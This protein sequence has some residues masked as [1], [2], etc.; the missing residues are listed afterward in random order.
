MINLLFLK[1]IPSDHE[2]GQSEC[3]SAEDDT[4]V[5]QD[6]GHEQLALRSYQMELADPALKG[7]NVIIVAPTGSGKT[8][9]ALYITKV[10]VVLRISIS[11]HNMSCIDYC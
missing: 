3:V 9:V 2:D 1:G 5:P 10:G 6:T 8:H 11:V 4:L 7:E